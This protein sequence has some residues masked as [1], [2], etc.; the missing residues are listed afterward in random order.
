[1]VN[2]YTRNDIKKVL[3]EFIC[4]SFLPYA[5]LDSF[6][7]TDSFMEKWIMDSTGILELLEF[8]E[9]RFD[10]EVEDEEVVPDN[11]DSVNNLISFIQGKFKH[12]SE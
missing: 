8:I 3:R 7:D 5:G 6:E 1:M 11:L 9:E 4:E 2:D 12:V 10:F